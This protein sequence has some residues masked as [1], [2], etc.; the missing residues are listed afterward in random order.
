M[1]SLILAFVVYFL[2]NFSAFA[3]EDGVI[4]LNDRMEET[5][6][7]D[8]TYY[9]EL[10]KVEDGAYHYKAY[11]LSGEIKMEGWYKDEAMEEPHGSFVYYYQS[12]QIESQGD[13]RDGEKVE[14]WQRFDRNGNEKPE[15]VYAV[16]PML[17]AIEKAKKK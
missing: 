9:C 3:V 16:L 2:G 13:F 10:V 1:K 12:G 7:K 17:K 11:F 15:K 8:A 5:K 6:K 4:Y 14:V